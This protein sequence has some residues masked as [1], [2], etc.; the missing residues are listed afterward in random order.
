MKYF[1]DE[2][3][4]NSGIH[5]LKRQVAF[6][7]ATDDAVADLRIDTQTDAMIITHNKKVH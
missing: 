1:I 4:I 6:K 7:S 5:I 2:N 3:R